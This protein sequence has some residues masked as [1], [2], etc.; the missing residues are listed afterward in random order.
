MSKQL[1]VVP[2]GNDFNIAHSLVSHVKITQ[3]KLV[4]KTDAIFFLMRVFS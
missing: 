1:A 4:N 2:V 3:V